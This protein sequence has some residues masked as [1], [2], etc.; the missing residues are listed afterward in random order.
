MASLFGNL[1]GYK[2]LR[3]WGLPSLARSVW[4]SSPQRST[5]FRERIHSPQSADSL[6]GVVT[7]R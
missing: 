4:A 5:D 7:P 1:M 2:H 6:S 3:E